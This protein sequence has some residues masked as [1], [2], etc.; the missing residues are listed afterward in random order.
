[1]KKKPPKK[2]AAAAKPHVWRIGERVMKQGMQGVYK[3]TRAGPDD[4]DLCLVGARF[5][6]FRVPI[7]LITPVE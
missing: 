5:E 1:M 7:R 3:I 4:V 6:L 2:V